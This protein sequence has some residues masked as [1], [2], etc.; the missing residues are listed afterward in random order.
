MGGVAWVKSLSS[1]MHLG[2]REAP[3]NVVV[4]SRS[5]LVDRLAWQRLKGLRSAVGHVSLREQTIHAAVHW[6]SWRS[7]NRSE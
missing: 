4:A 7:C 1:D 2:S 5:P 6:G 3:T